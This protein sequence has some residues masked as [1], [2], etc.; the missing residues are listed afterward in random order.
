MIKKVAK[1]LFILWQSRQGG[2]AY[3]K[4]WKYKKRKG[5]K[6]DWR[7]AQGGYPPYGHGHGYPGHYRPRGVKGLII[8]ALLRRMLHRR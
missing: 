2:Y 5:Y 3:G 4:P 7:W 6:H 8:D 1:L